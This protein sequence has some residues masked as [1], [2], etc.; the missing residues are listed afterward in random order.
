MRVRQRAASHDHGGRALGA[1]VD[2][3]LVAGQGTDW[4]GRRRDR[5]SGSPPRGPRSSRRTSMRSRSRASK[6]TVHRAPDWLVLHDIAADGRVLL[7]RNTIRIGLACRQPGDVRE[8]DL[9]LDAASSVQ[10]DSLPDGKTLIFEDELG[11]ASRATRRSFDEVWTALRRVPIGEGPV[12][13]CLPTG[14]GCWRRPATTWCSCQPEPGSMVTLPK[15]TAGEGARCGAWLADS[16]RIVF[17]GD[18]GNG[19]PRG[20]VQEIPSGVRVQRSPE[21]CD[22]RAKAAVRD[23]E[24]GSRTRRRLVEAVSH[25][26]AASASPFPR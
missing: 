5:R 17:T 6:R 23:D 22:A 11:A 7:S 21:R 26:R 8:R 20:Y 1:Q 24:F 2:V 10:R 4:P 13:H 12:R 14:N 16:K 25:S 15:G 9:D 3:S 19:I 18:T